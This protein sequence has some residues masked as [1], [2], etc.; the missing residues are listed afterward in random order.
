MRKIFFILFILPFI[1]IIAQEKLNLKMETFISASNDDIMP[2]WMY[3]NGW[4]KYSSEDRVY[5][6]FYVQGKYQLIVTPAFKM[7]IGAGAVVNS[8]LS[9]SFLHESYINGNLW[10]VDYSIGKEATSWV[11]YDDRLTSGSYLLSANARPVPKAIFGIKE[12]LPLGFTNNW[13]E[14]KG[15][16][17]HGWLNDDRTDNDL[18]AEDILLHEKWAYIRLGNLNVKPYVGLVHSALMGGTR[19]DGTKIPIDYWASFMAKGSAKIGGGE[20]TN[21]AGAH[22][23]L[24]DFGLYYGNENLDVQL[25]YQKPFADG[26]GMNINKGRNKDHILGLLISPK[27]S[28][29]LKGVSL[30]WIKTDVQSDYG[31]PDHLYPV[32][33]KNH[34]AGSIVWKEEVEDDLDDFMLVSFGEAKTGWT[35]SEV[36]Q[37][38][39]T[40]MNEGYLYGGRDD[41]MNNGTY[42]NAWTY[43]GLSM[44]SPLY[45]TISTAE[46]Y[47]NGEFNNHGIFINNRVNGFHLGISTQLNSNLLLKVKGTYTKNFGS[48]A[49][50]FAYRYSWDRVDDYF[51]AEGKKQY[52]TLIECCWMLSNIKKIE[53]NGVLGYDFGQLYSSVGGRVGVIYRPSF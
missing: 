25:Y 4:G 17:S 47:F 11:A 27:N 45:H 53:M 36:E 28:S 31:I 21:A 49:E 14:I 26:S 2:T 48:Y 40:E 39:I 51:Y 34:K 44:G 9:Q 12:Y 30:E 13:V 22:M 46:K 41:Y 37:Y 38:M 35:W 10:F 19:P 42:Y 50:E 1:Q 29:W 16:I 8:D 20:L 3:A 52:Y 15:A 23:G 6:S 18:S 43:N 32:D 5:G 24:W 33:Y 7:K